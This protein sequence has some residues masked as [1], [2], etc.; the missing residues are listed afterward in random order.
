MKAFIS[1]RDFLK[2]SAADDLHPAGRRSYGAAERAERQYG[3][4][5]RR[6][7]LSTGDRQPD[8]LRHRCR[9]AGQ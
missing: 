8:P 6:L 2:A 5:G 3:P 9:A 1:R 7:R 4:E